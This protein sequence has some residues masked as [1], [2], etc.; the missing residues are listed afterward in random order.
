[1]EHLRWTAHTRLDLKYDFVWITKHRKKLLRGD[2]AVNL[3]Q[4]V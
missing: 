1:M 4:L 2:V 3:R